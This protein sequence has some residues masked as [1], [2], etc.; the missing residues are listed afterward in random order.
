MRM[1]IDNLGIKRKYPETAEEYLLLEIEL[2][3]SENEALK[4][5]II[6]LKNDGR[7]YLSF[8]VDASTSES[9]YLVEIRK[10]SFGVKRVEE[11]EK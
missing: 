2:L 8:I 5:E 1:E 7:K 11:K 6:N 3:K 9:D 10:D 4:Q